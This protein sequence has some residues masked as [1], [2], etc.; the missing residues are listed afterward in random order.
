MNKAELVNAAKKIKGGRTHKKNN[1]RNNKNNTQVN[2][3]E[4]Q[5]QYFEPI[6]RREGRL[7]PPN[8]NIQADIQRRL[9]ESRRAYNEYMAQL[10]R[11][12]RNRK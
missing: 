10:E 4:N 9:A 6:T 2:L 1:G 11:I 3:Q 8:Y 12:Q 5:N 7:Y